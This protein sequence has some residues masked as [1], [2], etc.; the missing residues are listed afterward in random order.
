MINTSEITALAEHV[1]IWS[2]APS[3]DWIEGVKP[4]SR[5]NKGLNPLIDKFFPNLDSVK[6]IVEIGVEMGGG[7]RFFLNKFPS[8]I[9]ICVDPWCEGYVLP[10]IWSHLNAKAARSKNSLLPLFLA[11]NACNKDRI[12]PIQEF[13]SDGL[14]RVREL[15]FQPDL[16][17]IDGDH[18]YHGVFSDL[19]MANALFPEAQ[20]LGDDWN[21]TSAYPR[22]RGIQY[23]V[24]K[25]ATDFSEHVSRELVVIENSFLIGHR[26][27]GVKRWA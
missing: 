4:V 26:P 17:Y 21:F 12:L 23:S 6:V 25:A 5:N 3:R 7:T 1:A 10:K 19:V 27:A 13:S 24:Q 18:T 16:V 9:V 15:G 11:F 8:S 2:K 22:Y 14:I 20:I